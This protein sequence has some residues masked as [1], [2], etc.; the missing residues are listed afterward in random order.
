MDKNFSQIFIIWDK[1]FNTFQ[2]ELNEV[3]AVYGVK[4]PVRTWNPFLINFKHMWLIIS[5]AW[6]TRNWKDK[7]RI[8]YMPTGW[9]PE[10]VKT[11]RPVYA[12]EDVY[13]L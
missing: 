3:P 13:S 10:D 2:P 6:T 12:V 7:L 11:K 4:R 1:L 9:R 8:W 5:D